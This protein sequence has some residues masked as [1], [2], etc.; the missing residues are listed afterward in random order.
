MYDTDELN[1]LLVL[2]ERLETLEPDAVYNSVEEAEILEERRKLEEKQREFYEKVME[3]IGN[4]SSALKEI[5]DALAETF[6]TFIDCVKEVVEAISN[7]DDEPYDVVKI[8][9]MKGRKAK[10]RTV[11]RLLIPP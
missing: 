3:S 4:L 2:E 7:D 8:I 6:G 11:T 1:Q 5:I 9:V 10:H